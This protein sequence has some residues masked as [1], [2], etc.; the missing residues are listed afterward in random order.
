MTEFLPIMM[1]KQRAVDDTKVE[2][3]GSSEKPGWVL[4]GDELIDRA[5]ELSLGL[6]SS[7][8]NEPHNDAMPYVFEVKLDGRDTAKSKRTPVVDMLDIEGADGPS[9]VVGM[10]GSSS[11]IVQAKDESQVQVIA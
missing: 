5:Q 1:I 7:Y 10:K 8:D 6:L 4:T 9:H 11:L 2:P 3:G